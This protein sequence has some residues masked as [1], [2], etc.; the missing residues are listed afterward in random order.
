M[1]VCVM[2]VEC[3]YSAINK[4]K[5]PKALKVDLLQLLLVIVILV[6]HLMK[7]QVMPEHL[8]MA[9]LQGNVLE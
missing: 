2:V 4:L 8:L 6:L 7:T 1:Q 3:L 9:Q 5:S